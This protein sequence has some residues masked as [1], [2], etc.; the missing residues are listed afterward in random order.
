MIGVEEWVSRKLETVLR[1]GSLFLLHATQS[2]HASTNCEA[3]HFQPCF[4]TQTPSYLRSLALIM[5]I[6]AC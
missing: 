4:Q 2:A 3:V 5:G 6:I 1:L